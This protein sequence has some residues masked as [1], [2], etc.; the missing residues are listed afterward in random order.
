MK[1]HNSSDV[2]NPED[3]VSLISKK[4]SKFGGI[5]FLIN[6]AGVSVAARLEDLNESDWLAEFNL[7]VMAAVR[8]SELVIPSMRARGGG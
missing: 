7:K 6:N 8:L 1:A 4:T 3:C 5:D 2:T